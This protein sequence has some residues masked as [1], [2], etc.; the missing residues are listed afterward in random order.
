MEA[1]APSGKKYGYFIGF[2]A[3]AGAVGL[4]FARLNATQARPNTEVSQLGA[5]DAELERQLERIQRQVSQ[6]KSQSQ[7]QLVGATQPGAA[8]QSNGITLEPKPERQERRATAEEPELTEERLAEETARRVDRRYALLEQRFTSE[9]IDGT[10]TGTRA[11]PEE[12]TAREHIAALQGYQL[13]KIE[14]RYTMCRLELKADAPSA[15]MLSRL[16]FT[17]GGEIRR[18]PDGTFLAFAGREGF[19]FQE[20]NR[21]D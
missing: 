11:A 9:P 16:G 5:R 20:I 18:R 2:V 7:V 10:G 14:C 12:K 19:P 1:T 4:L 13:L 17:E 21:V 8:A 3:A 6:L 15:G